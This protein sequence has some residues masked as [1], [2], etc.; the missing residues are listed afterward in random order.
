[1]TPS[2][3]HRAAITGLL[4][5]PLLLG[6]CNRVPPSALDP[7]SA[8]NAFFAA[9]EHGDPHAAYDGSAFG[10]QAAQTYEAFLSNAEDIGL[11][12]GR[13]P[14]WSG[15]YPKESEIQ[16]TG[17]LAN[18]F[19]KLIN[20][21]VN[22]TRDGEAWKLFSL[23]TALANTNSEPENRFTL[24][25]HGAGFNDVY[26]QPMPDAPHLDELVVNSVT[27][28]GDAIN[29]QDFTPFYDS[30]S[31]QWKRGRL[32]SGKPM[33]AAVTPFILKNHF[34]GFIDKKIDLTIVGSLPP[35][36]DQPPPHIDEDG[37]LTVIGHF[38][39]R[40]SRVEFALQFAYELPRWKL[41]SI[42]VGIRQ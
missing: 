1:V 40:N 13:A 3:R 18:Q 10:F 11:I 4:C 17:T 23:E 21:T 27:R 12:N 41:V 29:R 14:I 9:V 24:V 31:E 35:V 34:Q 16:L 42:D 2:L 5:L 32:A 6:A 36:Y 30:L 26:H 38:D 25:G 15:T 22:M 20:I 37:F 8:A 28:L 19:G 7:A 33:G 39:I